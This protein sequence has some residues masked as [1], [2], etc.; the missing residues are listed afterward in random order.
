[1]T[2]VGSPRGMDGFLLDQSRRI[3]AQERRQTPSYDAAL[4]SIENLGSVGPG[5]NLVS[6]PSFERGLV[7]WDES[8]EDYSEVETLLFRTGSYSLSSPAGMDLRRK[9]QPFLIQAGATVEVSGWFA[10][11]GPARTVYVGLVRPDYLP[12]DGDWIHRIDIGPVE[13]TNGEWV[14]F[15]STFKAPS[16]SLLASLRIAALPDAGARIW[17]DDIVVREIEI[18]PALREAGRLAP[19]LK[20]NTGASSTSGGG[21]WVVDANGIYENGWYWGSGSSANSPTSSPF[22]LEVRQR[23]GGAGAMHQ[24]VQRLDPNS[25]YRNAEWTRYSRNGG[26]TWTDWALR[27]IPSGPFSVAVRSG[28]TVGNGTL[29]GEY[30]VAD[31][32]LSGR[33]SFQLGST[34]KITGEVRFRTPHE[35]EGALFRYGR[36]R[37]RI[38]GG[39]NYDIMTLVAGTSVFAR[40]VHSSSNGYSKQRGL[41][42]SRPAAWTTGSVLEMDFSYPCM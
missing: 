42:S 30:A 14:R 5:L 2:G 36:G 21:S 9:S 26:D 15:A 12:S 29:T 4:R 33:I 32:V 27:H 10:T 23:G 3:T 35:P 24:R 17:F 28:V 34:S 8:G 38:S 16:T 11:D 6:N 25:S 7:D 37:A 39:G 18:P 22:L 1:M 31:G 20:A 19:G 41:N 40:A 13:S